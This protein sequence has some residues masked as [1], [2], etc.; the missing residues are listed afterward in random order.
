MGG[1]MRARH[2]HRPAGQ[3]RRS[4]G[5]LVERARQGQR[6]RANARAVR[7]SA[8]R[9][10]RQRRRRH[11]RQCG[12]DAGDQLLRRRRTAPRASARAG[13]CRAFGCCGDGLGLGRHFAWHSGTAGCAVA[14]WRRVRRPGRRGGTG[15]DAP[16]GLPG[17]QDGAG[18]LDPPQRRRRAVGR[19]GTPL[20]EHDLQD[21]HKGPMIRALPLPLGEFSPPQAVADLYAFLL[22]PQ[23]RF[24]VGQIIM[25]DGG[26]EAAWR[27]DDWPRAWDIGRDAFMA[28]LFPTRPG[29]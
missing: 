14:R 21:P 28:R 19:C 13:R 29:P 4:A 10:G 25:I 6:R 1:Q 9:L 26:I 20:L 2:R 12:A 8:R 24:I 3:G 15:E 27:A 18:T 5:R 11:A 23:A 22:S 7:R 17:Q 16:I